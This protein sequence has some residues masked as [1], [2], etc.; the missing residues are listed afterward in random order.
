[1]KVFSKKRDYNTD[2]CIVSGEWGLHREMAVIESKVHTKQWRKTVWIGLRRWEV[3]K[4]RD[5][6]TLLSEIFLWLRQW[7]SR[8]S[9]VQDITKRLWQLNVAHRNYEHTYC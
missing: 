7:G 8:S 9:A 4:K 5:Y 6:D 1:M 3:D 2:H